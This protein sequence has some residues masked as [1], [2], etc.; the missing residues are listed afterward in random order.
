M[1]S[2]L[3]ATAIIPSSLGAEEQAPP[4]NNNRETKTSEFGL[5]ADYCVPSVEGFQME[6]GFVVWPRT[7]DV[8]AVWLQEG[9]SDHFMVVADVNVLG[10][11]DT[12][13]PVVPTDAPV[14]APVVGP[15]EEPVVEEPTDSPSPSAA[16]GNKLVTAAVMVAATLLAALF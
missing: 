9:L 6:D 10:E 7:M 3:T 11:G 5:R 16:S 12:P 14:E 8:E 15:T 4:E 1:D 13:A 2:P